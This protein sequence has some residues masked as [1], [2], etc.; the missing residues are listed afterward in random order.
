MRDSK[1]T[2]VYISGGITNVEGYMKNF[3]KAERKLIDEG[4]DSII[5]PAFVNSFLPLDFSH[6]EYMRVSLAMLE[7]CD[8][9]YMLK[10]WENSEGAKEEY[11]YANKLGLNIIKE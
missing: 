1:N 2:R 4:Y 8:A 9:I 3:D 7:C 10:G 6:E 5:N 11:V